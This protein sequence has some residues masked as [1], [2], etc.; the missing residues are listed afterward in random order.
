MEVPKEL[1]YTPKHMWVRIEEERA[2]IGLTDYAQLE[3]GMV[4]FA[5]LPQEGDE[6]TAGDYL[7]SMETVTDES[8]LFAPLSGKVVSANWLLRKEPHFI[9]RFP[10]GSGW[11]FVMEYN[12]PEE[13]E[14][15][16]T[17]ERYAEIYHAQE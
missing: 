9:N 1:L 16:W 6:V 15:L 7:G 2:V 4:V 11:L 5:D 14:L 3:M 8:E 17:A 13:L 10:Y 12:N